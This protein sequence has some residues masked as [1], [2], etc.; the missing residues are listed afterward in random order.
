M[1]RAIGNFYLVKNGRSITPTVIFLKREK[2][3]KRKLKIAIL[4]LSVAALLL[5]LS[6]CGDKNTSDLSAV[7][8]AGVLRVG[9]ECNYAPFNWTQATE[10]ESAVALSGGGYADGYDVQIALQL[11]EKLGVELE[12]VKLEW[13][14]LVPALESNKIDTIIAGMSPTDE[15]KVSIDFSNPYYTSE[16]VMVVMADGAYSEAEAI[17]DFSGAKITGQLSTCNYTVIDQ[18]EGVVKQTAMSDFPAMIVA[19]QGGKIEGYVAEL[20]AAMSAVEG[21]SDLKF[22]R[23]AEGNGFTAS[24]A[25]V[26]VSVG[27]R[28][29]SDLADSL[30]SALELIVAKDREELMDWAIANQ[31]LSEAN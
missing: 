13:E 5:S 20:P 15:R 28:K 30:N 19:L 11:A 24:E 10:S 3:M 27:L 31:P 21:N 2:K 6:A 17:S 4:M 16:L 25:E 23:F 22:I 1:W 26:S 7:Q 8:E 12:I 29:G 18:I 9:M 14:G